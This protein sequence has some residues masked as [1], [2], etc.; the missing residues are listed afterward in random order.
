VLLIFFYTKNLNNAIL[1]KKFCKLIE[2]EMK[3][4]IFLLSFLFLYSNCFCESDI[5][6][7][8]EIPS[9]TPPSLSVVQ[10]EVSQAEKDFEIAKKM[11][12]PWYGGPLITGSGVT[13]PKGTINIQPYI[14]YTV[15]YAAFDANRKSHSIKNLYI[16]NPQFGFGYGITDRISFGFLASWI[17]K[18]QSSQ[19]SNHFSDTQV[20]FD[21]GL[22]RE[23]PYIP[24]IKFTLKETF[25][26][27]RYENFNPNKATVEA[28][29]TGAYSTSFAIT[30]SKVLWFWLTHP[31][32]LRL[33]LN[34]TFSSNV[35]VKGFNSYGGGFSTDGKVKVG[36][37]FFISFG[38][39]FSFTQ[40]A[41]FALDLAYEYQN[42]ST[43][44]GING[45]TALGSIAPVGSLSRDVLSLAPALEYNFNQS[46][47]LVA[48]AWFS[49][50]GKNTSDFAAGIATI[51]YSF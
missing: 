42:K 33:S 34:Y 50:W 3:K 23:T 40:K 10:E 19:S 49:V 37:D 4:F 9:E 7:V 29:G 30:S 32:N 2:I 12:N 17:H 44:K 43:F 26:S 16:T 48:G 15:D 36:N 5:S 38:Y 21:F 35:N 8:S 11:F 27:G 14:F 51:I 45:T 22:V 13:L 28:T 20:G 31:M 24:A 18:K 39:E 25:P 6:Q 41:V 47:S 1:I 46:L